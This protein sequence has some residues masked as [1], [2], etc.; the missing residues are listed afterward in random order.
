MKKF[1]KLSLTSGFAIFAIANSAIAQE[2]DPFSPTGNGVINAV[3]EMVQGSEAT[4]QE[5]PQTAGD[6]LTSSQLPAYKVAGVLVSEDKKVAAVKAI[7]GATYIV[8]IGDSLGSEGGKISDITPKGIN[9]Q[10]AT[11]EVKIP[12]SNKIEVPVD[13]K[14]K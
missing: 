4:A 5:N 12:V 2:R 1:L 7:N 9:I 13:A 3:K 6:P 10:T 14:N 8:K 11:K